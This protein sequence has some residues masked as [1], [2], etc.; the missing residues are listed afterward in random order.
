MKKLKL[1]ASYVRLICLLLHRKF[2]KYVR[3]RFRIKGPPCYFLVVKRSKVLQKLNKRD[4]FCN[5]LS[6]TFYGVSLAKTD[7]LTKYIF[8]FVFGSF[9]EQDNLLNSFI[10]RVYVQRWPKCTYFK[11]KTEGH[12]I[13]RNLSGKKCMGVRG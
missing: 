4:R 5:F 3:I 10:L 13:G 11:T 6:L 2:K 1:I 9:F 8:K 7:L 12:S